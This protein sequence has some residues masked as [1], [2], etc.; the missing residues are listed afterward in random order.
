MFRVV[1]QIKRL[2]LDD[3]RDDK[4]F[5]VE[6]RLLERA[7]ARLRMAAEELLSKSQILYDLVVADAP[8]KHHVH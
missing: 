5:D 3:G 2:Y 4:T 6:Q 7:Q 8:S 1:N